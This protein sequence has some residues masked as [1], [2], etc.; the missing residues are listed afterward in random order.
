MARRNNRKRGR[1]IQ[2]EFTG[3]KPMPAVKPV[4]SPVADT[5]TTD[6]PVIDNVVK[7]GGFLASTK[8]FFSNMMQKS[9]S[10]L[11]ANRNGLVKAGIGL[12]VAAVVLAIITIIAK[13]M[14]GFSNM[15][16]GI[17]NAAV[18]GWNKVKS[19]FSTM[20]QK[21]KGLFVKEEADNHFSPDPTSAAKQ[22]APV[23][24][25]SVDVAK[26]AAA[27]A[28]A[29]PAVKPTVDAE[30]TAAAAPTVH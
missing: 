27:Q 24:Q 9:M 5:P 28:V 6:T 10:T 25:I 12:A 22:T 16:Q 1:I 17:K 13:T 3:I 26:Q 15:V 7:V 14:G 4:T 20:G 23:T 18:S 19:G 8:Q 21:I 30:P 29:K 2:P 11:K